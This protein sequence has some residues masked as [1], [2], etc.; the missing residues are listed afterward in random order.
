MAQ[1]TDSL[2]RT[3]DSDSTKPDTQM[4][5]QIYTLYA[6]ILHS[7]LP[8]AL[9]QNQTYANTSKSDTLGILKGSLW[10]VRKVTCS[11]LG[12]IDRATN[13]SPRWETGAW[14]A[15]VMGC[16]DDGVLFGFSGPWGF[17]DAEKTT[18]PVK[19][20]PMFENRQCR[21]FFFGLFGKI[22]RYILYRWNILCIYIYIVSFCFSSL[23][24]NISQLGNFQLQDRH[25][26]WL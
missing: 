23:Y 18:F 14:A 10:K 12:S 6:T 21:D 4:S 20:C 11:L 16:D 17:P 1:F 25:A 3:T 8:T 2:T 22:D 19:F 24:S 5:K 26:R 9:V 15:L 13:D 7:V